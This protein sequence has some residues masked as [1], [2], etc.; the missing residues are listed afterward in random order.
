MLFAKTIL[1]IIIVCTAVHIIQIPI[2]GEQSQSDNL[3]CHESAEWIRRV[4]G[5]KLGDNFPCFSIKKY[6]VGTH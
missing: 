6:V 5:D 3:Y 2:E 1:R 4:I